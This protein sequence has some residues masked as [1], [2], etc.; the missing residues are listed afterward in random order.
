MK[1]ILLVLLALGAPLLFAGGP[2]YTRYGYGDLL[3]YNGSRSYAMGG[4]GF[5]MLG[6]NFISR[7][8]PASLSQIIRTRFSA[9]L[10]FS[11]YTT[12]ST[13]G[14]ST[15][16]QAA[17]QGMALAV[18]LDKEYGIVFSFDATPYSAVSYTV[19]RSDTTL[20][21]TQEYFG[22]GGLSTLNLGL[23][24]SISPTIHFGAKFHYYYGRTNQLTKIDF[25]GSDRVDYSIDRSVYY[26]GLGLTL[27]S[28]IQDIGS[29]IQM[30]SLSKLDAG[31]ILGLPATLQARE[32]VTSSVVSDTTFL[33]DGTSGLPLS[34]GIGFLYR[35]N[36]RTNLVADLF[37][38]KWSG[39]SL[40]S[41]LP[42]FKPQN[43]LRISVGVEFLPAR[44][45]VSYWQRVVYRAGATY[46][47]TY[48]NI[49]TQTN[50]NGE[51]VN[52]ETI[53]EAL[54]TAGLG[55]PISVDARLNLGL[56]AGVRGTLANGLQ[57]DT[58]VRLSLSISG[59]ELWFLRF[60]EE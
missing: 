22:G 51:Y 44:D 40:Y 14:A 27:G 21:S 43:S 50:S 49:S 47:S 6:D 46:N 24:V 9:G 31:I 11:R 32:E 2:I 18:P 29:F 8:N 33:S 35:P 26:S 58:I 17:F 20:N 10:D 41:S 59:N 23:S 4:G 19:G 57:R 37:T 45:A 39:V 28:V 30:P 13:S 53:T 16:M 48:N 54:A 12:E 1:K 52:G 38:Q 15:F 34:F 5:A 36:E 3:F 60:D 25:S 56:Q 7:M 42:N 55:L